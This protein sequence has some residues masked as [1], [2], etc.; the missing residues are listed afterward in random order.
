MERHDLSGTASPDCQSM[1]PQ[2]NHPWLDRQSGLA[3]PWS[4]WVWKE[5][6]NYSFPDWRRFKL[7]VRFK[8]LEFGR[9]DFRPSLDAY[10]HAG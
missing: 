10:C 4:V 6:L 5:L 3:V 1:D 2:V 9:K 7:A 8:L